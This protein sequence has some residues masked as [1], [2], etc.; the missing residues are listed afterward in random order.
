MS[1]KKGWGLIGCA[2]AVL[3]I[4]S[5]LPSAAIAED[6]GLHSEVALYG[7]MKSLR[8]NIDGNDVS[9]N[10]FQDILENLDGALFLSYNGEI[11]RWAFFADY[12]YA[13]VGIDEKLSGSF[14]YPV[15][16][17]GRPIITVDATGKLDVTVEQEVFELGGG[18]SFYEDEDTSW[19]IIGGGRFYD[20]STVVKLKKIQLS[21]ELLPEPIEIPA[22]KLKLG[23]DWAQGFLGVRFASQV[24]EK[25]RLRGLYDYGYGGSDNRSWTA[26]FLMD[27]RFVD[28][29]SIEFGYRIQDVT[30]DNNKKNNHYVYDVKESGP[31]VGFIFLF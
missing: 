10:F 5:A 26:E 4:G 20:Q 6:G 21:T 25:W 30:Y 1:N 31:R 29:G 24:G 19:Q 28:W 9:L 8:G 11:G 7:W 22:Q 18:Y 3:T 23:D 27:W 13:D 14:E 12:Q 17:A 16:P 15:P 2:A